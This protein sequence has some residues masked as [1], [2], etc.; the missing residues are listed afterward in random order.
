VDWILLAILALL[1]AA[2]VIAFFTRQFA[3]GGGL[4]ILVVA[5]LAAIAFV[6]ASI[7]I[8]QLI[9]IA[10]LERKSADKVDMSD[11]FLAGQDMSEANLAGADF[12]Q[13]DFFAA[14]LSGADLSG[15]GLTKANLSRANLMNTNLTGA[16]AVNAVF[17]QT[18]LSG[19]VLTNTDLR[20]ADL[21][22]VRGLTSEQLLQAEMD[23]ASTVLPAGLDFDWQRYRQF[24]E[25]DKV[26]PDEQ[27]CPCP[28]AEPVAERPIETRS[29]LRK[30]IVRGIHFEPGEAS[31][32]EADQ[33]TLKHVADVMLADPALQL[34]VYGHTDAM[35]EPL[36]NMALGQARALAVQASLV[37]RSVPPQRIKVISQG[38]LAPLA[39]NGDI[40][41]RGLNRRVELMLL[42]ES[43]L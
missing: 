22:T 26:V 33:V 11:E 8:P 40:A 2:V 17:E 3:S 36:E 10:S 32:D 27:D 42:G 14:D 5:A 12:T 6:V 15:A 25:G 35:G 18:T 29:T 9:D 4:P 7:P 23:Q 16:Q 20:G 30:L 41:G 19:A 21:R 39:S 31:L 13:S 28:E 24:K 43:P 1:L 38:E 37:A 34:A